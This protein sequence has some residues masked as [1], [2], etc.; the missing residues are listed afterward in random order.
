M[1]IRIDT[2]GSIPAHIFMTDVDN[3]KL[4]LQIMKGRESE[5]ERTEKG[6]IK[7]RDLQYDIFL[8]GFM[9]FVEGLQAESMQ[10]VIF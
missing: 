1:Y 3:F 9:N 10:K 8:F 5:I 4:D 2:R 7:G 6:V